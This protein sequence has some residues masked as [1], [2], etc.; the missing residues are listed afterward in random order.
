MKKYL[1][2]AASCFCLLFLAGFAERL[3]M[4]GSR[5]EQPILPPYHS[6]YT[7]FS[8]PQHFLNDTTVPPLGYYDSANGVTDE[9]ATLGRVLF[10]DT[11]LSIHQEISCASCH[12]QEFAFA[13]PNPVSAGQDGSPGIRNSIGL[14][15]GAVPAAGRFFWDCRTD[16]MSKQILLA[17]TSSIEMNLDTNTLVDRLKQTNFYEPLFQDA[18][19]SPEITADKSIKAISQFVRSMFSFHAKYD[20]ARSGNLFGNIQDP[21]FAE[22]TALENQGLSLFNTHCESCHRGALFNTTRAHNNGLDEISTEEGYAIVSGLQEDY[23]KFK[24][25]SLRNIAV[26]APYMHDGRFNSLEEVVDFY[27]DQIQAN[28]NLD[29]LLKEA[30]G[31]PKRFLFT[32]TEKEALVAFLHTLTD[33]KFM[34]DPRWSDP[35]QPDADPNTIYDSGDFGI[36]ISIEQGLSGFPIKVFPNPATSRAELQI[37]NPQHEPHTVNITNLQGQTLMTYKTKTESVQIERRNL[38]AGTYIIHLIKDGY[39]VGQQKIQ[40]Q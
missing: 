16:S 19:N 17:I 39:R 31:H 15:N 22:F 34:T 3:H 21:P 32:E 33:Q 28:P 7:F 25:P 36:Y 23:G 5:L 11:R 27:S 13:D 4:T 24:A 26:T 40:F 30:D 29:P 37:H 35:F 14:S 10:Y 12:I 1:L 20:Y 38:P 18:F 8:L 6:N 2:I 9:G